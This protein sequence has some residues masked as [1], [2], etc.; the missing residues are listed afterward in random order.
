MTRRNTHPGPLYKSSELQLCKNGNKNNEISLRINSVNKVA[1]ELR[2]YKIQASRLNDISHITPASP[3]S[4]GH[5]GRSL[6]HCEIFAPED[7]IKKV[8]DIIHIAIVKVYEGL[9]HYWKYWQ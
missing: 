9:N 6:L 5:I 4:H 3:A 7:L 2:A 8:L 1:S